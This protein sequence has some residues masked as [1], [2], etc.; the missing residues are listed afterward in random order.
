MPLYEDGDPIQMNP[1]ALE[2]IASAA[3]SHA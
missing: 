2:E 1:D 3:D